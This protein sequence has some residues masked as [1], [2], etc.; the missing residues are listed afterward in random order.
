[1]KKIITIMMTFILIIG[2][3]GCGL[4]SKLKG[5]WY[6]E[7]E[8]VA[9]E[10]DGDKIV[11]YVS[12]Y[13]IDIAEYEVKYDKIIIRFESDDKPVVFR[14]VEIDGDELEFYDAEYGDY[15]RFEKSSKK[16]VYKMMDRE[17]Y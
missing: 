8:D 3:S 9:L 7:D 11:F 12:P 17:Y 5:F 15:M 14:N 1:M 6:C 16:E 13:D 2:V 10:F 4:K